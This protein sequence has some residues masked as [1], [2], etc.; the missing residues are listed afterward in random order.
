MHFCLN[1]LYP[2]NANSRGV[3][4]TFFPRHRIPSCPPCLKNADGP[5][6]N[7]HPSGSSP[8]ACTHVGSFARLLASNTPSPSRK[9][10][11][12]EYKSDIYCASVPIQ[13]GHSSEGLPVTGH[14]QAAQPA[15]CTATARRGRRHQTP[16]E[17]NIYIFITFSLNTWP[18]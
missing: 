1:C 5:A 9:A 15:A 10:E 11:G 17:N 18:L 7:Y 16:P 14:H 8:C 13:R 3:C 4:K 2:S 12:E 6:E